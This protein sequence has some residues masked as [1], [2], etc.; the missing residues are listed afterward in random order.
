MHSKCRYANAFRKAS[1]QSC[2]GKLSCL[3]NVILFSRSFDNALM[4]I[5]SLEKALETLAT[6][7]AEEIPAS[8]GLD[9]EEEKVLVIQNIH[10]VFSVFIKY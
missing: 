9:M 6:I 3:L 4:P 10:Y 7:K 5:V 1:H 8:E 2:D